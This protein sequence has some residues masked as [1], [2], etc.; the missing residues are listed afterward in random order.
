MNK[1]S[2]RPQKYNDKFINVQ[3]MGSLMWIAAPEEKQIPCNN[4][5][6][7]LNMTVIH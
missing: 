6:F 7:P 1:Y 5:Y 4:I 3:N 2:D